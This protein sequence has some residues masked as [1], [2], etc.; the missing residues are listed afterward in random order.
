[1]HHIE[2]LL[3][4]IIFCIVCVRQAAHSNKED[5]TLPWQQKGTDKLTNHELIDFVIHNEHD[6]RTIAVPQC[7]ALQ[8]SCVEVGVR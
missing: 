3:I 7:D 5:H 1:M 2:A 4:A 8:Y 6:L